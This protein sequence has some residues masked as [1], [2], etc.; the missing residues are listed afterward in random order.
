MIL[1]ENYLNMRKIECFKIRIL[2]SDLTH[3]FDIAFQKPVKDILCNRIG[4]SLNPVTI[5][6]DPFLFVYDG[7]LFLFYEMKRN[8]S[9]GVICMTSTTDLV[10]WTKAV[11]VLEEDFHLSYPFIFEDNGSIYMI[12][13]TSDVGD[14]RLYKADNKY[15]NHFSFYSTLISKDVVDTEIGYV[16]SSVY[17]NDGVYYLI[18]SIEKNKKNVLYLFTSDKLVGPY[19]QHPDSPICSNLKIG[20]N[21]GSFLKD[22]DGV[23]YRVAQDCQNKYGD[24]LHLLE[25]SRI[26]STSYKEHLIKENIIPTEID[27][28]KDGGHQLHC[29]NYLGRII[30]ATDAKEYNTFLISRFIHKSLY[31]IKSFFEK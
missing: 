27:F 24:N 7:R 12:P 5:V 3:I 14:V 1:S 23:L 4:L 9:P 18:T 25:V 30:V 13:E 17:L 31:V 6:A 10:H 28:Y 11:I 21:G 26:T 19:L 8:Y 16:D 15:L 22:K 20:R 29:I 2:E